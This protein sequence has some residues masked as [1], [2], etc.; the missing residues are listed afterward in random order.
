MAEQDDFD[1]I[2]GLACKHNRTMSFLAM[3]SNTYE[4]F[5]ER[6]GISIH[7]LHKSTAAVILDSEV[8]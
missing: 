3:D 6:L 8:N 4:I 1:V 2:A 7:S 5:A